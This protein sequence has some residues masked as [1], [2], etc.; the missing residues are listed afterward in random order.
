MTTPIPITLYHN[1]RCSKSRQVL[2]LL[3][4]AGVEPR[5]VDYLQEPLTQ[6]QLESLLLAMGLGARDLLRSQEAVYATLDLGNPQWSEQEL[7]AH[8]VAHPIL[9]NR[10][11]VVSPLGALLCRPPE[12]VL[13]LLPP[14]LGRSAVAHA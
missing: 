13:D 2:A 11:I 9:M 1:P 7:V 6:A 12:R 10:P 14:L 4:G 3:R 5:V 8:L